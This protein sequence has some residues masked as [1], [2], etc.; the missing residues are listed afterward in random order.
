VNSLVL[1]PKIN[2]EIAR[3]NFLFRASWLW[4]NLTVKLFTKCTPNDSGV[5]VPGSTPFSDMT[6]PISIVKRKLKN[7]LLETQ[8]QSPDDSLVKNWSMCNFLHPSQ[9]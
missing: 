3:C 1:L 6:T 4:N 7:I 5:M 9:Q 2:L 8:K